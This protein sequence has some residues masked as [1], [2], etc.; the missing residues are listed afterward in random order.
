MAHY[1]DTEAMMRYVR[2]IAEPTVDNPDH[3]EFYIDAIIDDE[4]NIAGR[5][6]LFGLQADLNRKLS[7]EHFYPLVVEKDGK[8]DYGRGFDAPANERYGSTDLRQGQIQVGRII[9]INA[10]NYGDLLYRISR[11]VPL[12]MG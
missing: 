2:I 5:H 4:N 3:P 9:H 10:S 8:I 7:Q 11:I 12:P 6:M 1:E